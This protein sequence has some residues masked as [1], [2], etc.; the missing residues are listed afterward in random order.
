MKIDGIV[1][2][3]NVIDVASSIAFYSAALDLA[4]ENKF[5]S[6]G[7]VRWAG[8]SCDEVTLMLNEHGEESESRR[9]R[10][11]HRDVGLS[12]LACREPPGSVA[13]ESLADVLQAHPTDRATRVSASRS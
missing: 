2:L 9:A 5:E 6:E 1:P 4:L 8:L 7:R 11:S 10:P 3:L 12:V 13:Q